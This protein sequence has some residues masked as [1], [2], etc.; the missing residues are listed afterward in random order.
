[1]VPDDTMCGGTVK[2]SGGL[3]VCG[4]SICDWR[5]IANAFGMKFKFCNRIA[6]VR[7]YKDFYAAN[8]KY[9]DWKRRS[10]L[11]KGNFILFFFF[12]AVESTLEIL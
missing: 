5:L 9:I 11:D 8:I 2:V 7:L 3:C 12:V 6:D 4:V 10:V 1:M